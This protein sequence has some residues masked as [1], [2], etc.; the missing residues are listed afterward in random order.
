[1]NFAKFGLLLVGVV[2]ALSGC[3]SSEKKG[4]EK[5]PATK[6]ERRDN[7]ASAAN[8]VGGARK[9][10]SAFARPG[11]RVSLEYADDGTWLGITAVASAPVGG[12]GAA[13]VEQATTVATLKARRNIAEFMGGELNSARSLRVISRG[14]QRSQAGTALRQSDEISSDD[15]VDE[16]SEAQVSTSH[17]RI[18]ESI[19]ETITQQS[20]AILRG[21]MT[22]REDHDREAGVVIVEVKATP[23][24]MG[25]ARSIREQ[26]ER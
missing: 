17:Q 19:R 14:V 21:L 16:S 18:A 22:V 11:G 4:S 12:R 9:A 15:E 26:M 13:A 10:S 25:A 3:A 24:S 23:Q 20:A 5:A 2:V 8:T 1:V 7:G 6:A